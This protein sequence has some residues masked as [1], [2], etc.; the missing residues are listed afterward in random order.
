M[1]TI[2]QI[3]QLANYSD[4]HVHRF[5]PGEMVFKLPIK[6]SL[7]Y[8]KITLLFSLIEKN[9]LTLETGYRILEADGSEEMYDRIIFC[10]H[11]PDALKILGEEATPHE[12]RVLGAF[13]YIYRYFY[14]L[15]IKVFSNF[16][17]FPFF[18]SDLYFHCDESFMPR[19]SSA[20]SAMN[21][22][23]TTS[24]GVCVTYWLNILQVP[25]V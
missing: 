10:V 11:A 3:T 1:S 6:Q 4:Q 12:R 19:N 18:C 13:Q 8:C 9:V 22:L 23:G 7:P 25:L 5:W 20:W 2:I 15:L 14:T 24:S 17:G 16:L 21:F